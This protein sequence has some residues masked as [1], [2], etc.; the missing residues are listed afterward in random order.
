MNKKLVLGITFPGSIVLLKGQAKY[1]KSKGYDVYLMSPPEIRINE[2]CKEEGCVHIPINIARTINP[3]KDLIILFQM[4]RKLKIIKP[5]IVNVGTPKMGLLGSMASALTGVKKRIY[6]C[7]GLR[8][9]HEK[10]F[11]RKLLMTTEKLSSFFSHIV[12][13]VGPALKYQAI[14]DHVFSEEKSVVINSGSSNGIQLEVFNPLL[15]EQYKKDKLKKDLEFEDKFIF[16]FVGRIQDR[17]GLNELYNVFNILFKS[18]HNIS[19]LIVGNATKGQISNPEL[20]SQLKRHPGIKWVGFKNNVPLYLSIMDVFV[21]P[22]WWE[23]F[24]NSLIQAAAMGIPIITTN[25]TGCRDAVKDGYNGILVPVRNEFALFNAMKLYLDNKKLRKEHGQ[26][27]MIW[28][29]NYKSEH[30]WEGLNNIYTS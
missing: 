1:F 10:G 16:G 19:L 5:D 27:G 18:N 24:S 26:N 2:Y 25:G 9:E 30:I 14:K 15:Y 21:L 28:A 6:T 17:K 8:Y 12:I 23:G 22:S 7:R 11:K 20:I 13:C 29:R 4:I 3:I